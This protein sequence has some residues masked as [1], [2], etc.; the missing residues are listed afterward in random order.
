MGSLYQRNDS[1]FWWMAYK[2]ATGKRRLESTQTND[3]KEAEK[4]LRAR[5]RQVAAD[6]AA[7][8]DTGPMT[9]GRYSELWLGERRRRKLRSVKDDEN[10]LKHVPASMR[11]MLLTDITTQDIQDVVNHAWHVNGLAPRMVHHIYAA[12]RLLFRKALKAKLIDATPCTLA[13]LDGELPP[14]VDAD[15][16]FRDAAIFTQAEAEALISDG[17]IPEYRRVLYGFLFLAG[18]RINEATPRRWTDYDP[19]AKPLGRLAV[20]SHWD[21]KAL[22]EVSGTKTGNSRSVPV[23]LSLAAML[24]RWKLSGW[25]KHHGRKPTPGDLIIPRPEGGV[26]SSVRAL[27]I[28]NENDLALFEARPRRLHD[29]RRT[30]ISLALEHGAPEAVLKRVTHGPSKAKVMDL[31]HTPSWPSLCAAV[32]KLPLRVRT[33]G[34]VE[35]ATATATA[36]TSEEK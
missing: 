6:K 15:P 26:L 35:L 9:L 1:G 19:T 22:E 32:E 27:A 13:V 2:D 34:V 28:L 10:R 30:F 23:H 7:G 8:V 20:V 24:A 36:K 16:T 17:R 29:A 18:L 5:L 4:R 14:K 25:E 3:R 12:L 11:G 21:S 31:Y 33:G